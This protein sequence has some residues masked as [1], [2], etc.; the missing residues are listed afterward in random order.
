MSLLT[1]SLSARLIAVTF[2]GTVVSLAVALWGMSNIDSSVNGYRTLVNVSVDSERTIAKMN[3]AFKVQVQEWKNVLIRGADSGQR[4]KYWGRFKKKQDEIRAL[5]AHL[6][7]ILKNKEALKL[8]NQFNQA[9]EEA[10]PKYEAGFRA[11]EQSGYNHTAGD[12]AVKGIDRA[13]AKLLVEAQDLI[14]QLVADESAAMDSSADAA[15]VTSISILLVAS[16]AILLALIFG[17]NRGLIRPTRELE[18]YFS[19]LAEGD[20]TVACKIHSQDEIGRLARSARTLQEYLLDVAASMKN[21]VASVDKAFTEVKA[22]SRQVSEAAAEQSSCSE[23][24][25]SAVDQMSTAAQE[26][27]SNATAAAEAVEDTRDISANG[28]RIMQSTVVGIN[29]LAEEIGNAADVVQKLEV[30]SQNIGTVLSVIQGIAEQTNLLAL[31]AAIEAA[32]AGEQG[33]GFAVVADEVRTLAQKTQDSTT[34]IQDIIDNIQKGAQA[35]VSAMSNGTERTSSSVS[36]VN[37]AGSAL[38]KINGQVM[39]IHDMNMQIAAASEEQTQVIE[40]ISSNVREIADLSV[41]TSEFATQGEESLDC[42]DDVK[43]EQ[44][45]LANRLRT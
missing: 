6:K 42:L 36:Q 21:S 17:F 2:L 15:F 35:A 33:R 40:E 9:Y 11:F 31:N 20:L 19:A 7:T 41:R 38:E 27:S 37:E 4:D 34:E 24:V 13:P 43:K 18:N 3:Y 16:V 14:S 8:V 30:E 12:K 25:A 44:I 28:T 32:R 26:I 10:M 29:Q 39:R 23:T 5:S 1:S 45:Q 22:S